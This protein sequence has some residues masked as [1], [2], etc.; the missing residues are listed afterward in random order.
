MI[1]V[2]LRSAEQEAALD[3]WLQATQDAGSPR[4][5]RW[6]TPEEFGKNFGVSPADIDRVTDWLRSHGFEDVK[7]AKSR[8]AIEFSGT[9]GQVRAAFRTTLHRYLVNGEWHRANST[10]PQIPAAL[11]NVVAGFAQLNDFEPQS[12]AIRG[13]GGAYNPETHRIEPDYTLGNTTDGYIIFVGPSDAATLYDIP[14]RYNAR[15]TGQAYDG[16][17]ATIGIA[18]DSNIDPAQNSNYRKTF[19]LPAKVTQVVVDGGDPGENGDAVEAYLDTQVSGGIAPNADVILYTA[20]N[21]YVEAGLWLAVVRALDDNQADIL[22]VSFGSCEQHLGAAGNTFVNHLWQQ[23]AAQGITVTVSTGNSGSAGCDNPNTELEATSGLAVN[24]IASTPYNI[25]V[26]GTDF[27]ALYSD[28]PTSFYQYVDTS[29]DLPGHRSALKYIPEQPWNDSTVPGHNTT[30]AEN[31][32]WNST[33]YPQDRNIAA[34]GGGVSSCIALS[35]GRC[36]QGYP[37]PSWQAGEAFLRTGRNLPDVS[38]LAGNGLYGATWGLCTDQEI[39][40]STGAKVVN[41]VGTPAT[42]NRFHL[43]GV[44]G[45]SASAPAFAGILALLKQ[46]MGARLGQADYALYSTAHSSARSFHAVTTGNNSVNCVSGTSGCAKNT[47]GFDFMTGYDTNSTYNLAAGLGSVDAA[48]L[49]ASWEPPALK[50]TSSSLTLN[51]SKTPL[52]VTHGARVTIDIGVSSKSGTPDGAVGLVDNIQP[53]TQP[54]SGSIGS[55][56]LAGGKV[57]GP[58]HNLPGGSYRLSAHYGGSS[59]FA[60]SDSNAIPVTVDAEPTITNLTIRGFYDPATGKPSTSPHYGAIAVIDAQPYGKSSSLAYPNGAATGTVTFMTGA[61]ALGTVPVGSNGVA[62]IQSRRLPGGTSQITAVY[63]G[64]ESFKASTSR[65]VAA[66]IAPASDSVSPPTIGN[67]GASSGQ[68][69]TFTTNITTGSYG[70]APTGTVTIRTGYT[71]LGQA[72]VRGMDGTDRTRASGI[73]VLTT[74][75]LPV[76]V[77]PVTAR[78]DGDSNYAPSGP[79][80]P[81]QLTVGRAYSDLT[82]IPS[83]QSIKVNQPL[84]VEVEVATVPGLAAPTGTVYVLYFGK[85]QYQSPTAQVVNGKASVTVDG[86]I[87][88]LGNQWLSV[89]YS[90]DQNYSGQNTSFS[91][92]VESTGTVVPAIELSPYNSKTTKDPFN[93]DV[94]IHGINGA[95]I[96]TGMVTVVL[97]WATATQELVNGEVF[98]SLSIT[99]GITTSMTI[100]YLGDRYYSGVSATDSVTAPSGKDVSGISVLP[101]KSQVPVGQSIGVDIQVWPDY[102]YPATASGAVVLWCGSY[103]S[104]A[105]ALKNGQTT[106]TIPGNTLPVGKDQLIVLYGGDSEYFPGWGSATV[107]VKP[108]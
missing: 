100:S 107:T 76:G 39:D 46:K 13:P 31:A 93:L 63:S 11:A 41:C 60:A 59:T 40:F 108:N 62:E 49:F 97:P 53:A 70:Q 96:A 36:V 12:Q 69:F 8:M 51:G 50:A 82:V 106:I 72:P 102:G 61:T 22:N 23:A 74:K 83:S 2:L 48:A 85:V 52:H 1:L 91:V 89:V 86:N 35:A 80:A 25:A 20:A 103:K 95:P 7:V 104:A 21:T 90:G 71:V 16:T 58:I 105:T 64:D 27:D 37:L 99:P 55:Y 66:T 78:Y 32:P 87:L 98:F 44:G 29:N 3:T 28:F 38:F 24:G 73:S 54:N 79:S 92:E 33:P 26:G 15:L 34:G 6:L 81:V 101:P 30:V 18:G 68:A 75:T 4:Y 14:N 43:S 65:P 10:D 88:P 17:G 84:S 5:H 94:K 56:V 9:A 77:Y 57:Q 42:G 19:G 67:D 47:F 45:T